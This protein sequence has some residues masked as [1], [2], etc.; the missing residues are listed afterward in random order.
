[1]KYSRLNLTLSSIVMSMMVC[2][3]LLSALLV[4]EKATVRAASRQ[5]AEGKNARARGN[6]KPTATPSPSPTPAITLEL[7]SRDAGKWAGTAPSQIA[8]SEDGSKLYFQWN[9]ERQDRTSLYELAVSGAAQPRKVKDEE[10]RFLTYHAG[11]RNREETMKVYAYLGDIYLHDLRTGKTIRVTET[12][13]AESQP[14]FTTS[15]PSAITFVRDN[16]LYEWMIETGQLRQL[17]DF[18]RGR[19]PEEKPKQSKEEE[20]LEHQQLE[21]FEILKKQERDE[22]ENRER[23]KRERGPR[24]DPTYLKEN[25]SIS[26]LQL[27]PDRKWVT[28]TLTDRAESSRAKVPVMPKHV[29]KSGYTETETLTG[30]GGGQGGGRVKVGVDQ[31]KVKMGVMETATGKIRYVDLGL[32]K[33]GYTF[34]STSNRGGGGGPGGFGGETVSWSD[35]GAKAFCVIAAQDNKDK[36]IVLLDVPNAKAKIVDKEHDDAWVQR[37]GPYDWMPDQQHI[38]FRSERDGYFHLYALNPETSTVKALT[39]GAWEVF[40]P[41]LSKDKKK[42]YFIS[43]ETHP[44]E[45]H[46]Y[47]MDLDGSEKTQITRGPGRYDVVF[48]SDETRLAV[49]HSSP[50]AGPNDLYLMEN[51][52]GAEMKRLTE[53][54]TAEFRAIPWKKFEIV[55]IKDADGYDLHA[56]LYKPDQPHPTRPAV[57][58]VHGAGYAQSVFNDWG[59]A[60]TTPFFNFLLQAGY[61]VLDLDYRGSAGYGRDCRTAIYR[62]MG[63][64]DI[65]SGV[66]AARWLVETQGVDARRIGIYGGSYGGFYTL[67]ALF[68]HPGA[69]AAGAALYPVTDWAHYN[70]SYTS[71][72]L[73]MP[74]DD[75]EAYQRSSPIYY[76]DK[77]QDRLLILHGMFDRNVHYQDSVRL[78]QRLIEL[79]KTGWELH[80][81]PIEDHGWREE[82]SRLDSNRRIFALFEEIL[83]RPLPAREGPK[84]A[85]PQKGKAGTN[86]ATR[87]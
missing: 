79:K 67:M 8:W 24:P 21:L 48:S 60:G 18:R 28:F 77:L 74:F 80:S 39:R 33:R 26:P 10:K 22:R 64:K 12:S 32:D 56:R 63:G 52:A 23:E 73:N 75:H 2:V 27:S 47:A 30:Q 53:S 31:P 3:S 43:S 57:I 17:T 29:T 20:Y 65:D 82:A 83:K 50:D 36:W 62:N 11:E 38:W 72:I 68:K 84:A 70:Q 13:D 42:F 34:V 5:Q 51:R 14:R 37:T 71:N 45:R 61:T 40:S 54:Y 25:E 1:M 15:G 4:S 58:Y 66:A 7:I 81:M 44:G 85:V 41:R 55:K 78:A 69:F 87:R 6:A 59:G 86:A 49:T 9:P 16:N 19:N 76:A 35:D 46:L